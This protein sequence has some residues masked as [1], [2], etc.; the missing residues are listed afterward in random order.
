MRPLRLLGR[1]FVIAVVVWVA[2]AVYLVGRA[3]TLFVRDGE[4]RRVAIA[5]LRG[6]TLREGMARLGATFVKLGQVLS[7]RPDLFDPELIDEL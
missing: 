3:R 7:T 6:R 4:A 1:F 5:R 2:L